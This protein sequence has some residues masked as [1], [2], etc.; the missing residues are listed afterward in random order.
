MKEEIAFRESDLKF[1]LQIESPG[2]DMVRDNFTVTIAGGG[3]ALKLEKTDLVDVV[4]VVDEEERHE[5]YICFASDYFLPGLLTCTVRAEVPDT[6]F[7][8]GIRREK[9]VFGLLLTK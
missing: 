6:D 3:K 4:V 2:F 9:D 8:G 1:L 5:Y 7:P